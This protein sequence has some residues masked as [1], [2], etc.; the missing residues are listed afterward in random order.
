MERIGTSWI[1]L[2][3]TR[4]SLRRSWSYPAHAHD[5]RQAVIDMVGSHNKLAT[6]TS[7]AD[8]RWE[9]DYSGAAKVELGRIRVCGGDVNLRIK[10]PLG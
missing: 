2:L 7:T 3:V 9:R 1:R 8:R 5:S 4:E 6:K 10:K